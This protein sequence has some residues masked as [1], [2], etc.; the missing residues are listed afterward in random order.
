MS[1]SL[2]VGGDRMFDFVGSTSKPWTSRIYLDAGAL[3]AGGSMLRA[4][5]RME[6]LLRQ[7]GY[8]DDALRFRRDA[9]GKHSERDWRRRA[10]PALRFLLSTSDARRKR[11]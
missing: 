7:R 4:A 1:P 10:P 6:K 8:G 9:K 3:E 2:W 5:E 11:A